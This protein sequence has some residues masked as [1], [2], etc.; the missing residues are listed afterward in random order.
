MSYL[1]VSTEEIRRLSFNTSNQPITALPFPLSTTNG[2][3]AIERWSGV[4]R[5]FIGALRNSGAVARRLLDE[6]NSESITIVCAGRDGTLALDDVYTAGVITR[7]LVDEDPRLELDET[8][9]LALHSLDAHTSA[10][11]NLESSQSAQLLKQVGLFGDVAYWSTHRA[12][13][14]NSDMA[15]GTTSG[16]NRTDRRRD[17][18]SRRWTPQD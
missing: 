6:H 9:L 10:K 12:S 4:R 5:T 18:I 2:S 17:S 14:L 15:A 13:F 1:T 8:A 3:F 11:E 16:I 7:Q